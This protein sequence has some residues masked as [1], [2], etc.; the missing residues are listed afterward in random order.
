MELPREE[1]Q[2]VVNAVFNVDSLVK[3]DLSESKPVNGSSNSFTA[4]ENASIE[5]FKNSA[6]LGFLKYKGKG[7][8][9]SE[10]SLP[11]V[12]GAE[13]SLKVRASGFDDAEAAEIL[14]AVPVIG[15]LRLIPGSQN[16]STYKSYTGTF[17]LNDA[18]EDNFY[19]LRVWQ[20]DKNN[21]KSLVY[22]S[23]KNNLG[24]FEHNGMMS[25]GAY[26]FDDK[27]FNGKS[28]A[29][30]FD[31]IQGFYTNDEGKYK[32]MFELL[33]TGKAYFNYQYD[34]RKK[35]GGSSIFNPEKSP[36][37]N[38]IK[39]GLG[40]FAPYNSATLIYD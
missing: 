34:V 16:N 21:F 13:Y 11:N 4:V 25:G 9:F 40:I 29:L 23:L 1:P 20:I 12:P 18:P 5:V 36:V 2:L 14:P 8:Y 19:F 15:D 39:S 35:S 27:S 38:N 3:V 26:L 22:A 6:S 32:L 17:T 37:S 7:Q 28:I 33:N 30:E 24:Q 31:L 10:T